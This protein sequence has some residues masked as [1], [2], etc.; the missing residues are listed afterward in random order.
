MNNNYIYKLTE[1]TNSL[2]SNQIENI[3]GWIKSLKEEELLY[4]YRIC[5]K[6]KEDRTLEEDYIIFKYSLTLYC[7]E[8]DINEI[9]INTDFVD[10]ITGTFCLN[11][12]TETLKK[13]K[14]I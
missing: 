1:K 7:R 13:N 3:E 14:Y 10:K 9:S 5:N 8:L 4:F 2:I 6:N 12:I 11:I